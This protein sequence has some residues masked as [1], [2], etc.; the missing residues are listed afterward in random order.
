M[1]DE[2]VVS[3]VEDSRLFASK[4]EIYFQPSPIFVARFSF[5]FLVALLSAR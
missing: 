3:W 5:F 1:V 2:R 4:I